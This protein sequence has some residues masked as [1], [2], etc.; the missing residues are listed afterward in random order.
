MPEKSYFRTSYRVEH[1]YYPLIQAKK[2]EYRQFLRAL[3]QELGCCI[4][5]EEGFTM[6]NIYR[7]PNDYLAPY[8]AKRYLDIFSIRCTGVVYVV[9][10][11]F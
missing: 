6:I 11:T 1:R 7:N 3:S 5:F 2:E 4:E 8:I 9:C 10:G